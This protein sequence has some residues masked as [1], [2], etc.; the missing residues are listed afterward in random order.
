M[1]GMV[2]KALDPTVMDALATAVD[3]R[4]ALVFL[5]EED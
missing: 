2:G 3:R 1:R 4:Q 5:D